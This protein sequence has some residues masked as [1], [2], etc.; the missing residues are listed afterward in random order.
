[1]L[2]GGFAAHHAFLVAEHLSHI[3]YLEEEIERVGDE[4]AQRLQAEHDAMTRLDTLPGVSQRTAEILVAEIGTDMSRFPS[5]KHL[6][7]WAGICPGN[8]QSA[9]KRLSGKTRK[10]SRWLRQVLMEA[11]HVA[12]KTKH[13]YLAAQYRRI[14]RRRGKKRALLALGHTILTIVYHILSRH[15]TYQ[16]LGA[17]YFDQQERHHLQRRLVRRLEKLG[18]QVALQPTLASA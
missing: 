5:A 15:T 4:I 18:F 13:T 17:D 7:S 12:A 16:E 8:H 14:A 11:A 10:G 1:V 2:E 6:A 9:G 3:D